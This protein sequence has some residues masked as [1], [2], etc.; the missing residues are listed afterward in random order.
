[1]LRPGSAPD[2]V[3]LKSWAAERLERWKLPDRI[4]FGAALPTGAT[5][6]ADRKALRAAVERGELQGEG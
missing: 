3:A 4:H 5:G 2:A 6:K 1:V